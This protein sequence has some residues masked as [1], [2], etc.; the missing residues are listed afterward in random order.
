MQA[1]L[2]AI[3]LFAG[4]GGLSLGLKA[5]GFHATAAVENNPDAASTYENEVG[6]DVIFKSSVRAIDFRSF[7]GIDLVAGGPPCQPFSIG[8]LRQGR[9]DIRDL[10]PEFVRAVLE[11]EPRGFLLEN[12]PGLATEEHREYLRE[13]LKPIL[14]RYSVSGPLL[15]NAADHG[16]P[17]SR[18]RMIIVG[19]RGREFRMPDG[20]TAQRVAAGTVLTKRPKGD[21]N[22]SKIVY[23]KNPDLRPNPYHGQLFNGGGRPIDLSTPAPTMLASAGGNKTHFLDIGEHVPRYHAHLARGGEPRQGELPDARRLTVAEC[24][25]LQ[26]FPTGMKFAGSR[27][28]QY[29]Q[30]G[31]AVP[32]KLAQVIGEAIAEQ[33]SIKSRRRQAVTA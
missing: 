7:K 29:K 18:R 14:D 25:A 16:V 6:A 13:V 28:S 17:Q 31:N 23:A 33:L 4:A 15:V 3:D 11:A 5:A 24:A 2:T 19:L 27:S 20:G 26:S 30:V 1:T 22:T 9:R 8:G 12:V 10:L 21:P 32:V